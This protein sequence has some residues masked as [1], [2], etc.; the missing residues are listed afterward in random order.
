MLSFQLVAYFLFLVYLK[1][2]EWMLLMWAKT[3]FY[4]SDVSDRNDP[5]LWR[6]ALMSDTLETL[7]IIGL[8]KAKDCCCKYHQN[9]IEPFS[10]G[11]KTFQTKCP[12]QIS[13]TM[14]IQWFPQLHWHPPIIFISFPTFN[15]P[16]YPK[17]FSSSLLLSF[18]NSVGGGQR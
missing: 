6:W 5:P 12:A 15:N 8:G 13:R 2:K 9:E 3:L 10:L 17:D 16:K 18:K 1:K 11:I 7:D 14:Y 4:E